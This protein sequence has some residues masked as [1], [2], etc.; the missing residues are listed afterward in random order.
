MKECNCNCFDCSENG[1]FNHCQN[2]NCYEIK[3]EITLITKMGGGGK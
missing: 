3:K 1:F 2:I